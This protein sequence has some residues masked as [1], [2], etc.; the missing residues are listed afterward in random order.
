MEQFV[1]VDNGKYINCNNITLW[2]RTWTVFWFAKSSFSP[3]SS[4]GLRNIY[5]ITWYKSA[6]EPVHHFTMM[7]TER[8][9]NKPFKKIIWGIN[10][11]LKITEAIL[12]VRLINYTIVYTHILCSQNENKTMSI[13]LLC[14]T[15]SEVDNFIHYL[16]IHIILYSQA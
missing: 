14:P 10:W 11:N 12:W 9:P 13:N 8:Y 16:Y 3:R 7:R 5:I 4:V 2:K 15:M 1:S 6:F